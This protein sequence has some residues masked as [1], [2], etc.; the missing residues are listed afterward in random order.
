MAYS[1]A[2]IRDY[3]VTPKASYTSEDWNPLTYDEAKVLPSNLSHIQYSCV[4]VLDF[5]FD[6]P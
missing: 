5:D 3:R 6:V 4:P 1:V 2:A